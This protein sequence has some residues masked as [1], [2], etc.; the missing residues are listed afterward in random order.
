LNSSVSVEAVNSQNRQLDWSYTSQPGLFSPVALGD[1]DGDGH[2]ELIVGSNNGTSNGS[3]A[4][5]DADTGKLKWQSP[6]SI[7]ANS[8][9]YLSTSRILLTPHANDA[10]MDIVLAGSA[11]YDGQITV[12]DG[13]SKNIKLQIGG[14]FQPPMQYR[15]LMDAALVDFDND[16]I[17]DFV[18]A[19]EPSSTGSSGAEL[20]VFSGIDGHPLWT[21]VQMGSGFANI[22]SVL[23][24]GPASSPTSELIAVLPGSL[25]AYNIQT[26]LLDWTLLASASGATFVPKGVNGAEIAVFQTTGAVTFY[27]AATQAYLRGFTLPSPVN[28]V[29]ALNGDAHDLL[30]AANGILDLID[31]ETGTIIASA[32][33]LGSSLGQ[34]N[35]LAAITHGGGTW[36]VASGDQ[37]GIAHHQLTFDSIFIDGFG[38]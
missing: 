14:Y 6:S 19:T 21:S 15:F 12:L 1:I 32:A 31:G 30:I 36:K 34:G 22:D 16:G 25:R 33:G 24:T 2:D 8:A 28:A 35:Q 29:T 27:D 37:I 18:A 26:R 17:P 38:D 9:F 13:A 23:V 10:A 3:I 4:I 20:Q 5:F 7:G 11:V